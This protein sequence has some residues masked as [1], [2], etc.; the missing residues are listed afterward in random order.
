VF[1]VARRYRTGSYPLHTVFQRPW[2]AKDRV[3]AQLAPILAA[4]NS[5]WYV[6]ARPWVDDYDGYITRA[7][8]ARYLVA[9]RAQFDGVNVIRFVR[10]NPGLGTP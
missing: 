3:D 10:E 7:L 2:L 8:E 5:I 6:R 1:D 9:E 4:C